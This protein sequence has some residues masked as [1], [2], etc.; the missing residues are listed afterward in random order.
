MSMENIDA[1]A[2]LQ[3][4]EDRHTAVPDGRQA[5]GEPG[6]AA[7]SGKST[8]TT[9]SPRYGTRLTRALLLSQD[10]RHAPQRIELVSRPFMVFGRYNEGSGKGFGDFALGFV[11]DPK[12]IS[13]LQFAV[14]AMEQGLVVMHLSNYA[15]NYTALNAVKLGQ[16]QWQ[17]LEA[18]DVIDI[19]GLYELKLSLSW[20][21]T[22]PMAAKEAQPVPGQALGKQLLQVVELLKQQEIDD[23]PALRQRLRD[24]YA[25]FLRQQDQTAQLNGVDRAG[26]LAFARFNRKDDGSQRVLHY[27]LPRRL[28]IGSSFQ[29]GL[30]IEAEGVAPRQAE[31][32]FKG[33]RYWLRNFGD[34]EAVR[35]SSAPLESDEP[36]PLEV[37]DT[38]AIGA[39]R[40]VF[41]SY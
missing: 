33:G 32:I 2:E 34:R 21:F 22:G 18:R 37:G 35:V 26:R 39:A 6:S 40:F 19:C 13:R 11:E 23:S 24:G 16:G 31:L 7:P 17:R 5:E 29:A 27:Y 30:R 20:D 12:K 1:S 25:Q 28:P 9:S 3:H 41:Q 8:A 14:C 15:G 4:A 38:I 10:V 36:L